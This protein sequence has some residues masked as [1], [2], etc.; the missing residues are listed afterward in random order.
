MSAIH[1]LPGL[2]DITKSEASISWEPFFEGVDVHWIYRDG[3]HGPAAALIRVIQS[4]RN[5]R[6]RFFRSRYA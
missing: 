2:L 1:L 6:F 3:E 4:R 5:S